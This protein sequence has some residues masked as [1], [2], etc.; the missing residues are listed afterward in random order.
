MTRNE[1]I[2]TKFNESIPYFVMNYGNPIE[3]CAIN[4]CAAYRDLRSIDESWASSTL[5]KTIKKM[6]KSIILNVMG[7]VN[8]YENHNR[9]NNDECV[10]A[11][12][13]MLRDE[14]SNRG[15]YF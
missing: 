2:A 6:P 10:N 14:A 4:L 15:I 7:E 11:V 5:T 3:D 9:F 8:S 13:Y 1:T 12:F